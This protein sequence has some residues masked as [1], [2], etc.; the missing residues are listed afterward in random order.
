MKT[1]ETQET[2]VSSMG[3]VVSALFGRQHL[4]AELSAAAAHYDGLIDCIERAGWEISRLEKVRH[5]LDETSQ[6]LLRDLLD[7]HPDMSEVEQRSFLE[8]F[9]AALRQFSAM[10]SKERDAFRAEYSRFA[11]LHARSLQQFVA[12]EA[13]S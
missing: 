11:E 7:S 9:H 1:Q 10:T 8:P 5:V 4:A 2:F 12:T 13:A 3:H 6:A